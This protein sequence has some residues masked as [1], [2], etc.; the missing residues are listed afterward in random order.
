MEEVKEAMFSIGPN[1]SHSH[2]GMNSRLYKGFLGCGWGDVTEFV[3][4]CLN[5][6]FFPDHLNDTNVVL[7]P[8]KQSIETVV[9][10]RLIALCNVVYKIMAKMLANRMRSLLEGIILES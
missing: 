1:K 4:G 2:D 10:L 9:D 5:S 8:K 3:L 6:R 7:I